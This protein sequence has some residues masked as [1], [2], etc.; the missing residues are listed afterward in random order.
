MPSTTYSEFGHDTEA[1]DVA[2]AFADRIRGKTVIVTGGN[3]NGIAFTTAEAFV[4]TTSN[5]YSTIT[6]H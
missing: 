2:K 4:R 5:S 1:R 6:S 3:R